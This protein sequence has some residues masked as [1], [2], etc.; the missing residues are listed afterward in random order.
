MRVTM[1]AYAGILTCAVITGAGAGAHAQ[2]TSTLTHSF[3]F[4]GAQ[5]VASDGDTIFLSAGAGIYVLDG[6]A[7]QPAFATA[8]T[9]VKTKLHAG[10]L[11]R[12]IELSEDYVYV[13]ATRKGVARFNRPTMDVDPE[14]FSAL[15]NEAEGWAVTQQAVGLTDVVLV[16]TNAGD[17]TGTLELLW[18][19]SRG[20]LELKSS[21]SVGGPVYCL[22]STIDTQNEKLIVLVGTACSGGTVSADAVQQYEFDISSGAPDEIPSSPVGSWSVMDGASPLPTL[23]R[24]IVSIRQAA[25]HT[26]LPTPEEFTD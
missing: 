15:T 12:D 20:G 13:A 4:A 11:V 26:L 8:P 22:A 23:A 9:G 17:T 6:S 18:S 25:L 24:D 16:G 1:I 10:G 3:P 14:A 21:H 2:V 7:D 5:T 19:T